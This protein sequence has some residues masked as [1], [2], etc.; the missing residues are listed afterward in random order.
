[1]YPFDGE[2]VPGSVPGRLAIGHDWTQGP[3]SFDGEPA[4]S[5][6]V[7]RGYLDPAGEKGIHRAYGGFARD[8]SLESP[9][10]AAWKVSP[11]EGLL[12]DYRTMIDWSV[13]CGL[14]AIASNLMSSAP[15]SPHTARQRACLQAADE[16][17]TFRVVIQ[18]DMNTT[19]VNLS[20]AAL[21]A[22]VAALVKGHR[23]A[24]RLQSGALVVSPFKAEA[25]STSKWSSFRVE[26]AKLVGPEAFWP[27][28]VNW[29][30]RLAE[31]AKISDRVGVWGERTPGGA[32][33]MVTAGREVAGYRVGWIAPVAVQD[34]RPKRQEV[35][36]AEGFAALI[37]LVD[38]AIATDAEVVLVPT[39]NDIS[40]SSNV[41]PSM[42]A[43]WARC[44]M[45]A[46]Q[47]HR[48][49]HGAEPATVRPATIVSQRVHAWDAL[50]TDQTALATWRGGTPVN[51]RETL[52]F[53]PG[54]PLERTVAPATYPAGRPSRQDLSYHSEL[55][56]DPTPTDPRDVK[57]AQL[58][59][60]LAESVVARAL[61]EGREAHAL[62]QLA[63]RDATIA[64]VHART[65]PTA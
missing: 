19:L 43:G 54:K 29:P 47:L 40:E 50:P 16:H 30:G 51:I 44:V 14:D 62:E 21:A 52:T 11:A 55:T 7:T 23:S 10:L 39:L 57:I 2:H 15:T 13:R 28:L 22:Y 12:A 53:R 64:D 60:L 1:M 3:I 56:V 24:F 34:Y 8:R 42:N 37:A 48:W 38:A 4:A 27:I 58:E 59:A 63:A 26:L 36:E 45:L 9:N 46:H 49:R 32:A 65:A 33:R 35:W 25:W 5:D 20:A 6:F 41:L 61:A 18:P 17:P 31:F